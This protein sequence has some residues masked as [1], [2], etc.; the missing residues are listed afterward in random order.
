MPISETG[1]FEYGQFGL[2]EGARIDELP[3]DVF[4]EFS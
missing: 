2:V 1:P 4:G 3:A